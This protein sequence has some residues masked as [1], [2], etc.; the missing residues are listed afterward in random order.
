MNWRDRA[1]CIDSPLD[2]L[3]E[4]NL[5]T[6]RPICEA[7]PVRGDCLTRAVELGSDA[8]GIWA[9]TTYQQRLRLRKET[10]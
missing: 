6:A 8:R 5:E 3:D 4:E 7:C 10:G 1:A 9:G 2:W